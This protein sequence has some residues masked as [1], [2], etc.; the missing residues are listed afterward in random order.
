MLVYWKTK[1]NQM[2]ITKEFTKEETLII[3]EIARVALSYGKVSDYFAEQLDLSDEEINKLLK[4][5]TK[6]MC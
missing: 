1:G 5:I 3:L 2:K 6:V 4:K